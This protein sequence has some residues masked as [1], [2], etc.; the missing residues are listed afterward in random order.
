MKCYFFYKIYKIY[1]VIVIE[2]VSSDNQT[3][4]LDSES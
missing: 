1:K 2:M 4:K 3:F